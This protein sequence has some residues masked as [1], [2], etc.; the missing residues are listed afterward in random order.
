MAEEKSRRES[1]K[2][3]KAKVK[4]RNNLRRMVIPFYA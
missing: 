4:K 2:V 1:T 3:N